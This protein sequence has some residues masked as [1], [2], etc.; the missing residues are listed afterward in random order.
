VLA[1]FGDVKT[2]EVKAAVAKAFAN[3]KAGPAANIQI[4]NSRFQTPSSNRM[5]ETRDK[6]QA[7]I[8]IGFRGTTLHDADRFALDLLQETC[9]DLGSR[10]FLRVREKLG[11]AYFVG[12]Q[13]FPGLAP[14]YFSFYCGTMPEQVDVVEK[15]LL[16]EAELLRTEGLTEAELG[17]AKAKI[18]GQKKIARQDL[19]GL[20]LTTALDEIYGLGFGNID[21]E[22]A[23]YEAVTLDQAKAVAQKYLQ[24]DAVV[25]A[26]VRP[27][28]I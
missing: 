28:K 15:E 7:V 5:T 27:E 12:A 17:R 25:V 14:G 26:V 22:D 16:R 19:G 21:R 2:A 23:L 11:L 3:W 9:S 20:A 1:I 13:N 18:I 8:V 24:P 4:P 6:K 10:L